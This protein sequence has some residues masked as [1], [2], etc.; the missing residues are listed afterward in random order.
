MLAEAEENGTPSPGAA[1]RAARAG[2]LGAGERRE[3]RVED[4]SERAAACVT[5][6]AGGAPSAC[7]EAARAGRG[8][9]R[10]DDDRRPT[11]VLVGWWMAASAAA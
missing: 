5:C 6:E 3:D 1:L 8:S 10:A 9:G 7:Q 11:T 4:G 2:F